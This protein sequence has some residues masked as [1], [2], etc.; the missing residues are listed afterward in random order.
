LGALDDG[1]SRDRAETRLSPGDIVLLLTD[2]V[3][4]ACPHHPAAFGRHRVT[5]IVRSH[6]QEPADRIVESLGAAV[7][8]YCQPYPPADDFTVIVVK[9]S[10]D[11]EFV[12][13]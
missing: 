10:P 9:V 4:E 11:I 1:E 5:E 2:G 3:R 6:L 8:E 13:L 7:W 12:P